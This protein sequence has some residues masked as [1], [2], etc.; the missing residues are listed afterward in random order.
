M[1]TGETDKLSVLEIDQK[2]GLGEEVRSKDWARDVRD[3]EGVRDTEGVEHQGE[4]LGPESLNG[5]P[6]CCNEP[7]G[8][9]RRRPVNEGDRV[10][11][12][13][14]ATID[15]EEP[16]GRFVAQRHRPA[17]ERDGGDGRRSC[18]GGYCR[19]A[20]PFPDNGV[21]LMTFL[22]GQV[23]GLSQRNASLP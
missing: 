21:V 20:G 22:M 1:R 16:P 2:T 7:A 17:S 4:H 9:G 3:E 8:A 12:D 6:V 5:G 23:V 10:N 15:Q 11:G 19:P 13:I 14:R 18:A